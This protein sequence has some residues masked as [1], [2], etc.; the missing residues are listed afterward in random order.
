MCFERGRSNSIGLRAVRTPSSSAVFSS[1]LAVPRS[2]CGVRRELSVG[3]L[4]L[5]G[6]VT[7]CGAECGLPCH[8]TPPPGVPPCWVALE[9]EN[10]A[11]AVCWRVVE[12]PGGVIGEESMKNSSSRE[13]GRS[14][15]VDKVVEE[16]APGPGPG[17]NLRSRGG[18]GLVDIFPELDMI[19]RE[20]VNGLQCQASGRHCGSKHTAPGLAARKTAW[21]RRTPCENPVW[22]KNGSRVHNTVGSRKSLKSNIT[23]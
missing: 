22:W 16:A 2:L 3:S 6:F 19:A 23:L 8:H 4:P 9:G 13:G 21:W 7:C 5:S 14:E 15:V 20:N 18:S 17:D 10:E 1:P 11:A 12:P